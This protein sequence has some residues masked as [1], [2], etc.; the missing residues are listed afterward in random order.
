LFGPTGNW[1]LTGEENGFSLGPSNEVF[2]AR[3]P[4]TGNPADGSFG[5]P[6]SIGSEGA[7]AAF[8]GRPGRKNDRQ[9]AGLR[10]GARWPARLVALVDTA[11]AMRYLVRI[12]N[13]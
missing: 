7:E 13:T 8:L 5:A 12:L 9:S 11:Q 6:Y 3:R 4:P 1:T 10:P 2:S